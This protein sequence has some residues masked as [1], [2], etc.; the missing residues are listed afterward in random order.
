MQI[1]EDKKDLITHEINTFR[2]KH[3]VGIYNLGA[4]S[5][6]LKTR[7]FLYQKS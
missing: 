4:E 6:F 2:E 5:V 1:D 3:K 7:H